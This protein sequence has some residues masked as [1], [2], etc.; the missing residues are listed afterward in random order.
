MINNQNLTVLS[1]KVAYLENALKTAGVLPEVSASDNGKALQVVNGAWATGSLMP[2][3]LPAVSEIDNSKGLIVSSGAWSIGNIKDPIEI[4]NIAP[5][6]YNSWGLALEVIETAFDNLSDEEK[7]KSCILLASNI[8]RYMGT[9]KEFAFLSGKIQ[10][11]VVTTQ[12]AII[13]L[14]SHFLITTELAASGITPG[15]LTSLAQTNSIKLITY[16]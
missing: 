13:D 4:I 15:N 2:E 5:N 12:V 14:T 11:S 10:A 9:S 16:P 8:Y 1:E 6:E 3:G 7:L